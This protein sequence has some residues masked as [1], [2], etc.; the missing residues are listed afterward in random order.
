MCQ[1][2]QNQR[3]LRR[4]W[5]GSPMDAAFCR[6]SLALSSKLAAQEFRWEQ[7][8]KGPELPLKGPEQTPVG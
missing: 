7:R 6:G 3:G 8:V 5:G 1:H 4:E 2:Q